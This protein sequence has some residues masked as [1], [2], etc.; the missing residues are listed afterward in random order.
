MVQ[1]PEEAVLWR[2]AR[3]AMLMAGDSSVPDVLVTRP[4]AV[5]GKEPPLS[6]GLQ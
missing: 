4:N 1:R 6:A 2:L 5:L 3:S